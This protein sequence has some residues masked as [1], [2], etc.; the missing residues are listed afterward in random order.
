M[1]DTAAVLHIADRRREV[2]RRQRHDAVVPGNH[3]FVI[4]VGALADGAPEF[5]ADLG[6]AHVGL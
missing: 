3:Q 4:I 6:V 2:R 5:V 1:L